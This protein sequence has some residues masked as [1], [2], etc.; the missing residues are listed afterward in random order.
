MKKMG[1]RL[2]VVFGTAVAGMAPVV[3]SAA[4]GDFDITSVTT[5]L[6]TVGAA[7]LAALGAGALIRVGFLGYRYFKKTANVA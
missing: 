5:E 3:A 1:K 7:I 2:A 4:T 6:G